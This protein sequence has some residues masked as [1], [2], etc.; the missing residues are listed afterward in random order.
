MTV[1]TVLPLW[2]ASYRSGGPKTPL[3]GGWKSWT[4]W[5]YTASGS[6][7]GIR[8]AV[9]ESAYAG[10]Q[11]QLDALADPTRPAPAGGPAPLPLPVRLPVRLP[12]LPRVPTVPTSHVDLS[13]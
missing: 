10:S 4:F 13:R 7:S 6:Q 1:T 8:G 3:P 2:I 12:G 5:Q 11:A 9:D